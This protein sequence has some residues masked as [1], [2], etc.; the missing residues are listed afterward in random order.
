MGTPEH[1]SVKKASVF[2][3]ENAN[4]T[5]S[6]IAVAKKNRPHYICGL[7]YTRTWNIKEGRSAA[8]TQ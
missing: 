5:V 4:V 1:C 3:A 2:K 6:H 7:N 8:V